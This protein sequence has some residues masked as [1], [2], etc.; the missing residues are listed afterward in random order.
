MGY[1]Q[2]GYSIVLAILFLYALTLVFRRRRLNRAVALLVDASRADGQ[3]PFLAGA[4]AVAEDGFPGGAAPARS[5]GQ[6]PVRT[7]PDARGGM[8]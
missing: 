7:G 3:P 8:S 5:P 4:A 2:A 6:E 1:V